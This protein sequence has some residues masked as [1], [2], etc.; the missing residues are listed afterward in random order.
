MEPW[1]ALSLCTA[2][3]LLFVALLYATAAGRGDRDADRAIMARFLSVAVTSAVCGGAVAVAL[4]PPF[5]TR[6]GLVPS[7][8][9]LLPL[10]ATVVLFCGPLVQM[11]VDDGLDP[12]R[13]QHVWSQLR[14]NA[15]SLIWWR[16]YVV[17]PVAEEW[18]FRACM[19]P[20]LLEAGFSAPSCVLIPPLFFGVAHT[21]HVLGLMRERGASAAQATVTVLFQVFYT[22]L[23]GAM[24]AFYFLATGSVFGPMLSHSFCNVMGFPDF[25]DALDAQR[26]RRALVV[27]SYVAGIL[28][29][30]ALMAVMHRD[31]A[32][33]FAGRS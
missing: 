5:L 11:I 15:R 16:N 2:F 27:A 1:V 10:F 21:H 12:W 18:V 9:F 30:A 4:G 33:L 23:F 14:R 31:V 26:P 32:A 28:G 24:A 13:P 17:A 3:L 6:V 8:S 25:A 20:L 22:T 19:I 7:W 29:Y